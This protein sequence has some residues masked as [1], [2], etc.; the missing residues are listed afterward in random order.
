MRERITLLD[1]AE[2]DVR[3]CEHILS[4]LQTDELM[5]DIAAYHIQQAVEKALK[6]WL[7]TI[8]IEYPR[9]HD[10]N[11]LIA[12][13]ETE[14]QTIPNWLYDGSDLLNRYATSSR[15]GESVVAVQRKIE[16]F[17]ENT[18]AL[19]RQLAPKKIDETT[20]IP[21]A[22]ANLLVSIQSPRRHV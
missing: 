21:E 19:L 4:A 10:I 8:G 9:T 18:R 16:F 11:A 7:S 17:C 3:V 22:A 12:L 13:L 14:R 5:K 1:R 2:S 6:Y 15:Y 20:H